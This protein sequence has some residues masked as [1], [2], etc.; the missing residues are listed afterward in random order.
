M[1][2]NNLAINDIMEKA[3]HAWASAPP[4]LQYTL[5][6]LGALSL[7]K[8]LGAFARLLLNSFI[9]SG[10]NVSCFARAMLSRRNLG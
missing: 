6:A 3:L 2:L 8:G 10:Y 7:L 4:A 1:A 5:A 9:L